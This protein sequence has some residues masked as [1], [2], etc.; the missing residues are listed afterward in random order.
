MRDSI[1]FYRSFYEAISNLED[2]DRLEAY[3]AIIGYGL[4]GEEIE[5]SG[6]ARALFLMA[7][8]QIDANQRRYENGKKGGTGIKPEPKP[9]LDRT[10]PEPNENVNENVNVN[11]KHICPDAVDQSGIDSTCDESGADIV[12]DESDDIPYK[13]IMEYLNTRLGT[14]Y[15]HTSRNNKQLI[16]ARWAEGYRLE[17][18]K[19]VIDNMVSRWKDDPKMSEYLR[20]ATLFSPKFEGYLNILKKPKVPNN[21][22]INFEQ[23]DIDFEQM[24]R[25][26]DAG[27]NDWIEKVDST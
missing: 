19:K 4:T 15:K 13:D 11:E 17:D 24:E 25:D 8:P 26:L 27:F 16:H 9:N 10:K 7:K 3:E 1:V 6:I 22:F 2:K 18:F 12:E 5:C 20:P 23:R 14:Q 21:G